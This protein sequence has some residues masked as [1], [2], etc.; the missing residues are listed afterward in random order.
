VDRIEQI[1]ERPLKH[2][3]IDFKP[4]LELL[5]LSHG[6]D[7]GW[8][9]Q[10]LKRR[11]PNQPEFAFPFGGGEM[12]N[13]PYLSW[14]LRLAD[15][16]DLDGSRAPAIVL[17]HLGI[18]D[19]VSVAE[20][21]KHRAV[22]DYRF[23]SGQSVL[24]YHAPECPDPYIE[25]RIRETVGS[26]NAELRNVEWERLR[27][28][29]AGLSGKYAIA[30]PREA[31][32][33]IDPAWENGRPCYEY[34][35]YRFELRQDE[36]LEILMGEQL[37]GEP[38]LCI[39]ELLQ[40]S[41]DAL[42]LRDLRLRL[43][44][45][46]CLEPVDPL[47]PGEELHVEL[48]W[49]EEDGRPFIR[50]RDNGVGMTRRI[51]EQYFTQVGRS[52]YRSSEFEAERAAFQR[53]GRVAAPISR[54]GIGILSCFM[55]A[56]QVVVKTCPCGAD[57]DRNI[58][59][60]HRIRKPYEVRITGAGSLFW[61][62]EWDNPPGPG[63]EITL[64]LKPGLRVDHDAEQ[65]YDRIRKHFGYR[66]RT[67]SPHEVGLSY[68][69]PALEAA[70][71]VVWPKYPIHCRPDVDEPGSPGTICLDDRFH[72]R[73][74][75]AIDDIRLEEKAAE[76]GL[77]PRPEWLRQIDWR[78]VDWEDDHYTG[79]R[80]RL[81][82]PARATDAA[83]VLGSPIDDQAALAAAFIEPQLPE[84]FDSRTVVLIFGMNVEAVKPVEFLE[85]FPM[86][87]RVGG[88]CWID[89]RGA[90][91]P[92][93]RADRKAAVR[94]QPDDLAAEGH[95]VWQRFVQYLRQWLDTAG[96]GW[97]RLFATAFPSKVTCEYNP[98][99]LPLRQWRPLPTFSLTMSTSLFLQEAMAKQEIV[100]ACTF[101][102]PFTLKPAV[103]RDLYRAL[104]RDRD[105]DIAHTD[106]RKAARLRDL[107]FDLDLADAL[108]LAFALAY[109]IVDAFDIAHGCDLVHALG[110][111][112]ARAF[113][114]ASDFG[115]T[116]ER[117]AVGTYDIA[118][119]LELA[120][121]LDLAR[122]LDRGHTPNS[123]E[124]LLQ[125][126]MLSEAFH[127]T[128]ERALPAIN[129]FNR[130]GHVGHAVLLGPLVLCC[131]Y[132]VDGCTLVPAD[133]T[134]QATLASIGDYDLVSPL[135]AIPLGTLRAQCPLWMTERHYR[136]L[137]VLPF[138]FGGRMKTADFEAL[139]SWYR[140]HLKVPDLL[141]LLPD[142]TLLDRL[143][144]DWTPD[145]W[146]NHVW[147][148]YWRIEGDTVLWAPGRRTRAEMR[149]AVTQPLPDI[150][151]LDD[152]I[153][154]DWAGTE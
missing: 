17:K 103:V 134:G 34:H 68:I 98:K 112:R 140:E 5:G 33:R 84:G 28:V 116:Y 154:T 152:W 56:D 107:A 143:F 62:R 115:I 11:W 54:F 128:L 101:T 94:R 104:A 27:L 19:G 78:L 10:R 148:A 85:R 7:I 111:S 25:K 118:P 133:P 125:T 132:A 136:A 3:Q 24:E 51:I 131:Q 127:P 69:D 6:Q 4:H 58:P 74:L 86:A 89:L 60:A 153:R 126:P 124:L 31:R 121:V 70:R 12:L 66:M 65:F 45:G 9:C 26:I 53:H 147:S 137:A 93:L 32:A 75:L 50:V 47:R 142:T 15:I 55:L 108:I 113:V 95:Q 71:A 145:D 2:H 59:D 141:L 117:V 14:L 87:A 30:V 151:T 72:F 97:N 102:L 144:T 90:A 64:Y 109:S 35:D 100:C 77:S 120:R 20:W 96:L 29:G 99:E 138:V 123:L 57:R 46:E 23:E 76:W 83:D 18:R 88:V 122:A 42:E 39:R 82:V 139:W 61:L 105:R 129:E 40:N 73:E 149:A 1:V 49:G 52:Y 21:A 48:T 119:L 81:A 67:T 135:T 37:Y 80:I 114:P 92:I 150:R 43:P 36:I 16:M 146:A 130:R 22:I 44:P 91:A 79:T 13:L 38:E 8:I 110:L 106:Y 63:T 41:L